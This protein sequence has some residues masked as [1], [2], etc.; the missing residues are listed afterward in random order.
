LVLSRWRHFGLHHLISDFSPTTPDKLQ[1]MP[2][3]SYKHTNLFI[4]FSQQGRNPIVDP[5]TTPQTLQ[6]GRR[7]RGLPLQRPLVWPTSSRPPPL[8]RAPTRSCARHGRSTT[9]PLQSTGRGRISI[10][11]RLIPRPHPHL[12]I[13]PAAVLS[14][15][16]TA[17]HIGILVIWLLRCI[18]LSCSILDAFVHRCSISL[19]AHLCILILLD[20]AVHSS[21]SP[22]RIGASFSFS[23]THVRIGA[24]QFSKTKCTNVSDVL[25]TYCI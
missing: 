2:P 4:S 5:Q 25:C 8:I 12:S 6:P 17:A 24:S 10:L 3:P 19:W 7:R 14:A 11:C 15:T 1:T 9:P 20:A 13:S 18:I 16:P 23:R 22:E 21:F